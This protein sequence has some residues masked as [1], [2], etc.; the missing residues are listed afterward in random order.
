[1]TDGG[2]KSE[3]Q[4]KTQEQAIHA[5]K[6]ESDLAERLKESSAEVMRVWEERVRAEVPAAQD[7]NTQALRNELPRFLDT[8]A[9]AFSSSE[10]D[11]AV[12]NEVVEEHGEQRAL[13]THYSAEQV[14]QEYRLFRESVFQVLERSDAL[15]PGDRKIIHSAIDQAMAEA[16]SKFFLAERS[17]SE[18]NFQALANSI[19]Q[20]AWMADQGGSRFWFNQRWFDFTGLSV[21]DVRDES[22]MRKVHHPD[23]LERIQKRYLEH[24]HAG[25]PWEDTFPLKDKNGDWHWFLSRAMP[26]KN[27]YGN[28]VRWFGTNTDITDQKKIETE[29]RDALERLDIATSVARIGIWDMDVGSP[30]I[31][32][33][34]EQY[35]IFGVAPTTSPMTYDVF[36]KTILPEDRQV[37]RDEYENALREKRDFF[38]EFRIL[39]ENQV[40]WIRGNGRI[41][42]DC[43]GKPSRVIGSN[44]DV[45]DTKFTLEE[46]EKAIEDLTKE[47]DL[48]ERFVAALTHDLR[49]PLTSAKMAGQLIARTQSIP[50]SCRKLAVRV[51][52]SIER[53]DEMITDLLDASRIRAGL[54]ILLQLSDCDLRQIVSN[55]VDELTTT[56]GGRFVVEGDSEMKGRWDC[57]GVR[58]I[59]E[60]LCINAVKYG[61]PGSPITLSCTL[62]SGIAVVVVRN[63]IH[64]NPI[65][66]DDLKNVFNPYHRATTPGMVSKKGWGLGLTVVKGI[67]EAHGGAVS[68]HSDGGTKFT[69]RLPSQRLDS[70]ASAGIKTEHFYFAYCWIISERTERKNSNA[71]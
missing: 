45:S 4:K 53:A 6:A 9:T 55:T 31:R 32:W 5:A 47:R 67:A 17:E 36:Y 8:L 14:I 35:E 37:V 30:N 48:R 11:R 49:T 19:P 41:Y 21:N 64:E 29:L 59:I 2:K 43:S 38:S 63:E 10:E 42:Y 69:L 60:N 70:S 34:K 51:V 66:A 7:E 62:E 16:T 22:W 40:R 23:H 12:I 54:P 33:S 50:D 46:R 52:D 18:R 57:N 15:D 56:Y 68:V 28:V 61:K 27:E 65:C 71:S 25:T 39:R 1:M 13:Y 58:R 26:I 24:V 3:Q 20:L 44:V